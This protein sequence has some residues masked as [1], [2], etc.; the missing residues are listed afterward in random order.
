M[1]RAGIARCIAGAGRQRSAPVRFALAL[2]A[3]S[4][5]Q[6]ALAGCAA[7]RIDDRARVSVVQD[8]DTLLLADGRRLRLIGI[9][10]PELE[11]DGRAAEAGAIAARERLRQLVFG[12]GRQLQLRFD[13]D[14]QD[15]YGR[16]LAHAFLD[17]GRNVT[18][19]L[20]AE[21]VGAHIVVPPNAW[22]AECYRAAGVAAR[23]QR[24]GVWA[25]ASHQPRPV[26]EL[27]LRSEG[28]QVVRGR[29]THIGHSAEHLWINFDG[30]FALRVARSDLTYFQGFDFDGLA[31]AE[32]VVHGWLYA[33]KGQ[34][35]MALR[36]P[37]A[38]Q[39]VRAGTPRNAPPSLH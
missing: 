12:S 4:L 29:V 36:H 1:P 24:R 22:L 7:D 10:T 38:L 15:R 39:V 5:S 31:G 21:G 28:F 35:R 33:R 26:Q 16:L 11:R 3:C 30:N 9:N 27:T 23:S 17:D 2:L 20:L 6:P 14:R 8:G 13:R 18:E 37:S 25:L 32:V 19:L 34:L